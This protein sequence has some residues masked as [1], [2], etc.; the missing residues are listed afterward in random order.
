MIGRAASGVEIELLEGIHRDLDGRR[1]VHRVVHLNM[2]HGD[3]LL[4]EAV[5]LL[6]VRGKSP[7]ALLGSSRFVGCDFLIV[8]P[9]PI[10]GKLPPLL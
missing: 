3:F 8:E 10:V 4:P 2:S 5:N 1:P 7:R 6:P 9:Q